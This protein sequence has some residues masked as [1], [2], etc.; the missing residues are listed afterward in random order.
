MIERVSSTGINA[1]S[2]ESRVPSTIKVDSSEA[3]VQTR[4]GEIKSQICSYKNLEIDISSLNFK[5]CVNFSCLFDVYKSQ[6][7]R[8]W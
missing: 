7:L 5:P 1:I 3:S 8:Y 2:Y 6:L 4:N